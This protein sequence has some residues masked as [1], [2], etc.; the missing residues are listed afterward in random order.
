M[1][2]TDIASLSSAISGIAVVAS[3]VFLYFQ[4]RQV[5][6]QVKQ[7]EKNQRSIVEQGRSTRV[8][9]IQMHVASE[10]TL[11]VAVE[12][13]MTGA[14][15]MTQTEFT[16]FRLYT[17]ARFALS[18]DTFLQHKNGLMSDEAFATWERTFVVGFGAPGPRVMWK[19][20][21]QSYDPEFVA[22]TDKIM[23]RAV[24]RGGDDLARWNTDLAAEKATGGTA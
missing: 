18:E 6:A 15:D 22:F 14:A 11:A 21:R 9:D 19:W 8:S 13:A 5:T 4:I 3:L 24:V 23:A 2:L 20:V 7:A 17:Y 10:P 16:Q 1:T 12:K